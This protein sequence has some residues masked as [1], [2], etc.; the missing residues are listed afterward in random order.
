MS[1][2]DPA[3]FAS[4]LNDV[5]FYPGTQPRSLIYPIDREG[6]Q[7]AYSRLQPGTSPDE[8]S[9]ESLGPWSD[10]SFH[11]RGDFDIGSEEI[12]FGVA[13]RNGLAQPWAFG[14]EPSGI[15]QDNLLLSGS[16]TW[17]GALI[18]MTPSGRSVLGDASLSFDMEDFFGHLEF[19]GMHF[20]GGGT[21]G[22]GDLR[23]AIRADD[24][25][26][27]FRRAAAEFETMELPGTDYGHAYVWTGEDLGTVWRDNL[28]EIRATIRIRFLAA[29][30]C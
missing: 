29:T 19:A 21:W 17:T 22:D 25:G 1:H 6:L 5:G 16:A 10:T 27:T 12:A 13:F 18:G 30:A 24:R 20:A 9:A 8:I 2:T 26:N 23:Y 11:L 3:R 28:Y 4:V 14:P 7:A 15:L